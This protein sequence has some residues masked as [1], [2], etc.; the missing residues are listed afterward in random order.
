[1]NPLFAASLLDNPL[2]VIAIVVGGMI[3][4]WLSQRRK[5]QQA[6]EQSLEERQPPAAGKPPGEFNLEETLRELMGEKPVPPPLPR[7]FPTPPP[8]ISPA[9]E[10]RP[11]QT[12]LEVPVETPPPVAAK[13]A[14]VASFAIP[15]TPEQAAVRF[16]QLNEQG[17]NPA[18]AQDLRRRHRPRAGTR[19]AMWSNREKVRTAFVASLVFAPPKGLEE[20]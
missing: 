7:T 1:M 14:G 16:E 17:R 9:A 5:A 13:R 20:S 18:K 10:A 15:Q 4:N 2:V 12:W 3:V 19:A 6:E 11:Q 8:M